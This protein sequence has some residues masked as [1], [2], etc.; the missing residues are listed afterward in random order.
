MTPLSFSAWVLFSW[1]SGIDSVADVVGYLP[2]SLLLGRCT[3]RLSAAGLV[4]DTSYLCPSL[5]NS[6]LPDR[7]P[8]IL[9]M[10]GRRHFIPRPYLVTSLTDVND[11]GYKT[12]TFASGQ[13]KIY[14][15]VHS[16]ALYE[17]RLRLDLSQPPFFLSQEASLSSLQVSPESTSSSTLLHGLF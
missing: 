9:E 13:H 3:Q 8:L 1:A 16:R 11:P 7:S 17:V 6:A 12:Q 15:A 14:S 2:E 5:E 4:A 10:I